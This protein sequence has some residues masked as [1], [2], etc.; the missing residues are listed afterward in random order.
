MYKISVRNIP[1]CTTAVNNGEKDAPLNDGIDASSE[2]A[3]SFKYVSPAGS[4][5]TNT[6][7][8]APVSGIFEFKPLEWLFSLFKISNNTNAVPGK[9]CTGKRSQI[10]RVD[11][12][13]AKES[14]TCDDGNPQV[15]YKNVTEVLNESDEYSCAGDVI[16]D[17]KLN[18]EFN[19]F[20]RYKDARD[21]VAG[22]CASLNTPYTKVPKSGSIYPTTIDAVPVQTGELAEVSTIPGGINLDNGVNGGSGSDIMDYCARLVGDPVI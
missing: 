7:F 22:I 18:A 16:F 3:A 15:C 5:T 11:C 20:P 1:A 10:V 6:L 19:T 8:G 2:W 14:C 9:E 21:G 12:D 17:A 13:P 4:V